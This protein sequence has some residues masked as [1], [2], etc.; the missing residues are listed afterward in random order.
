MRSLFSNT[1]FARFDL[2][3]HLLAQNGEKVTD[4]F[5]PQA[6]RDTIL[7]D[8]QAAMAKTKPL[9]DLIAWSGDNDPGLRKYLGSDATRFLALSNSIAPLYGIV[10]MVQTRL[11]DPDPDYWLVADED[12]AAVKQWTT[13]INQMN[14]I[15]NNRKV[16]PYTVPPGTKP[17][18]PT[19]TT[20][21]ASLPG[22]TGLSTQD[23]LVGGAVALGLGILIA[24]VA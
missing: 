23:F 12:L 18:P 17:L 2:G 5:L 7:L 13:G 14:L 10:E 20:A 15:L 9:E 8:I 6:Q 11:S 19:V 4:P 16:V 22:A 21:T 24:A 1:P 3:R